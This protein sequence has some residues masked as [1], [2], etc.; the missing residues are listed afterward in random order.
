MSSLSMPQSGLPANMKSRS[1]GVKL[2]VVCGL[3]LVM[4]IPAL[5]VYFLL[6]DRTTRGAEVVREI[7]NLVGG[8]QTFLGPTLAIPYTIPPQSTTDFAKHGVYLVFPVRATANVKTATEERHRSLFKVPVFQADLKLDA[9]FDLTG[10]PS[11]A[12][13]G[14][15]LDWNRAEI[16]V[17]VS[18]ARGALAD[19]TLT[20]NGKTATLEPA[21]ISS[22][23][24]ISRDQVQQ[25]RLT[26]FGA[27]AGEFAKPNAQFSVT[28]TLRFSGAQ[29]I[30][31]L[32]YGNNSSRRAG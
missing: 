14:A 6:E 30:A 1:M 4:T 13:P 20:A 9:T 11:A 2:I 25:T 15:E 17:G 8:Q 18:D 31:V 3:A 12:P 23:F 19:G 7:G 26:L 5:F 10:V 28:S 24:S 27:K 16:V 32:A 21:E 22:D 29:R